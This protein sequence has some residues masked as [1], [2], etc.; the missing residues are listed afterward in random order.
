MIITPNL[1]YSLCFNAPTSGPILV[2]SI[3]F[4][5]QKYFRRSSA[6]FF[7]LCTLFHVCNISQ[8]LYCHLVCHISK[9]ASS[10]SCVF[11]FF[12]CCCNNSKRAFFSLHLLKV[13]ILY[14]DFGADIT[15]PSSLFSGSPANTSSIK[16]TANIYRLSSA[17][18]GFTV[19][20]IA[21]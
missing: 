2:K 4:M 5:L 19:V 13:F 11:L 18:S 6:D 15:Y 8:N 20:K 3:L 7:V 10:P 1:Y 21:R 17:M 14:L 12:R 16:N 9:Q